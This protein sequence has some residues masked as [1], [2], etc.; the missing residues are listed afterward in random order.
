[1]APAAAAASFRVSTGLSLRSGERAW[2]ADAPGELSIRQRLK[3]TTER[4]V[5]DGMAAVD[6]YLAR[7]DDPLLKGLP[8]FDQ[9][10]FRGKGGRGGGRGGGGGGGRGGG[11]GGDAGSGAMDVS[12]DPLLQGLPMFNSLSP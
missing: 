9:S 4:H 11:G 5:G 7:S 8:S 6:A 10:A 12:D 1:V 3:F 2:A